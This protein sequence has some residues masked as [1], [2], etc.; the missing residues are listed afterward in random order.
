[1][2]V[3]RMQK[4]NELLLQALGQVILKELEMPKSV[5]VTLIKVETSKD[6]DHCK[7]FVS[8]FPEKSTEDVLRILSS[9]A[10]NLHQALNKKLF[11]RRVPKLRFVEEKE[12]KQAHKIDQLLHEVETLQ[13]EQK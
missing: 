12:L 1:M 6:L 2:E 5:L 9:Q 8:V 13:N 11:I 10:Y 7:V 4:I 3:D